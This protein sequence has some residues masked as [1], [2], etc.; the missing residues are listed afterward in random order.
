MRLIVD[1]VEFTPM[2]RAVVS[3]YGETLLVAPGNV[4]ETVVG[5]TVRVEFVRPGEGENISVLL[6]GA[7]RFVSVRPEALVAD[8]KW[9]RERIFDLTK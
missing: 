2:N 6:V 8:N 7:D 5:P 3:A 1:N 9:D 4:I